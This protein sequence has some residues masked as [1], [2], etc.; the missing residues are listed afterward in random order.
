MANASYDVRGMRT[1]SVSAIKDAVTNYK[2]QINKAGTIDAALA[3]QKIA[4]YA[5]GDKSVTEY[6]KLISNINTQISTIISTLDLLTKSID[7]AAKNYKGV[8][9]VAAVGASLIASK[10]KS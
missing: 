3:K 2:N 1:S 9:G 7:N 5:Q 4:K 8:D 6:N 10:I